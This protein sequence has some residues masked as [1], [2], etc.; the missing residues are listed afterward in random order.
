[1]TAS[2]GRKKNG[3]KRTDVDEI[4]I[5][6]EI[7]IG[8]LGL[9]SGGRRRELTKLAA[10]ASN[11]AAAINAEADPLRIPIRHAS[12]AK[13]NQLRNATPAARPPVERLRAWARTSS[14]RASAGI[15]R[16]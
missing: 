2:P 5:A 6:P 7:K 8:R 4:A 16:G 11:Q 12:G 13:R 9:P 3:P 1:M 15:S 10:A 14:A